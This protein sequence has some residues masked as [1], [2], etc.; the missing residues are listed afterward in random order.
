VINNAADQT[1]LIFTRIAEKCRF[2]FLRFATSLKLKNEETHHGERF[3]HVMSTQICAH[4][5]RS[6]HQYQLLKHFWLREALTDNLPWCV[7]TLITTFLPSIHQLQSVLEFAPDV[8]FDDGDFRF[9]SWAGQY[10]RVTCFPSHNRKDGVVL[11]RE[12]LAAYLLDELSWS[13]INPQCPL[14]AFPTVLDQLVSLGL[15]I[16][17]K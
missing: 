15:I 5:P 4:D 12:V 14:A 1:R 10:W 7:I 3:L 9:E 13:Q 17:K 16:D 2:A 8:Y 6:I 11:C